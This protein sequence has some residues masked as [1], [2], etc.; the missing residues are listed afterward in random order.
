MNL[1]EILP[2]ISCAAQAG[3][4]AVARVGGAIPGELLC[5]MTVNTALLAVVL[6]G[7]I[8]LLLPFG[9]GRARGGHSRTER[10]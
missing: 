5:S 1:F 2:T 10:S 4:D 3:W 8:R 7:A 6:L 9:A